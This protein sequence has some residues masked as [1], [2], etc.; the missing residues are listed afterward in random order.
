MPL[1]VLVMPA[2]APAVVSAALVLVMLVWLHVAHIVLVCVDTS[3][4]SLLF[5]YVTQPTRAPLWLV[6]AR[7]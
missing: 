1:V 7:H 2:V 3:L 4:G 5:L 6:R